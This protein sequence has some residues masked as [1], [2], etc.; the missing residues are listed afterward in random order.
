[1][2]EFPNNNPEEN[3]NQEPTSA[4]VLANMPSFEEMRRQNAVPEGVRDEQDYREYQAEQQARS[5]E[6]DKADAE[7]IEH[8]NK[9]IAEIDR[10][11]NP[12]DKY[13]A[14]ASLRYMTDI[15]RNK[16]R[17]NNTE[18]AQDVMLEFFNRN[19]KDE[20]IRGF[21]GNKVDGLR[22][23]G[24]SEEE[25]NHYDLPIEYTEYMEKI[26]KGA[27][28]QAV[29]DAEET[30]EWLEE[31]NERVRRG[32]VDSDLVNFGEW[33]HTKK[34]PDSDRGIIVSMSDELGDECWR[35][36]NIEYDFDNDRVTRDR[37]RDYRDF[38]IDKLIYLSNYY[39][40]GES[41]DRQINRMKE[42]FYSEV[43]ECMEKKSSNEGYYRVDY[44]GAMNMM[45]VMQVKD[46][47]DEQ[48]K[49]YESFQEQLAEGQ[50]ILDNFKNNSRA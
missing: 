10:I 4:D 47:F 46:E 31:F 22:K 27:K 50:Q 49:K 25:I 36:S 19:D 29:N 30:E 32:A 38:A 6:Q 21:I 34:R 35:L 11:E 8:S 18:N 45:A 44:Y 3:T 33:E 37:A 13:M 23:N 43:M 16:S 1:M 48:K 20:T 5:A 2:E 28:I 12:Q 39:T 42:H 40:Y 14:I 41:F 24:A 7:F 26:E 9:Y 17:Q 15:K